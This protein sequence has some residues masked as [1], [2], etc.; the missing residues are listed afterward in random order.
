LKWESSHLIKIKMREWCPSFA[1][2]M[3]RD[4]SFVPFPVRAMKG[5]D[6]F[7]NHSILSTFLQNL[8]IH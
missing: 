8:A 7:H 3:V 1:D 6:F 4:N 2:K 5:S